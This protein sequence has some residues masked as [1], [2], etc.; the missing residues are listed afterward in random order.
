GLLDR[1]RYRG[2]DGREHEYR[3][4]VHPPSYGA[5]ATAASWLRACTPPSAVAIS[6]QPGWVYLLSGRATVMWP[7]QHDSATIDRFMTSGPAD[8][9][10]VEHHPLDLAQNPALVQFVSTSPAWH[11]VAAFDAG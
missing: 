11:R 8:Y 1:V 6:Q 10:L 9:V 2:V 4:V 3:A 5:L 7:F